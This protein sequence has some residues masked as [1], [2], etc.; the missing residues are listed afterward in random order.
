MTNAFFPLS[1]AIAKYRVRLCTIRLR[2]YYIRIRYK[3]YFQY[4]LYINC[5]YV[6]VAIYEVCTSTYYNTYVCMYTVCTQGVNYH[7]ISKHW[8]KYSALFHH[9][10]RSFRNITTPHM[11]KSKFRQF[12]KKRND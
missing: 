10:H 7:D 8:R 12:T 4:K 1:Y 11:A 6:L 5:T 2:T 9:Y 3:I